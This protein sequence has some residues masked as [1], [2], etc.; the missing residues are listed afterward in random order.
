[1]NQ[2]ENPEIIKPDYIFVE[3]LL[4]SPGKFKVVTGEI[5]LKNKIYDKNLH[6]PQLA[7]AGFTE[8]FT[9][10]R[11]QIFGNTEMY[12]LNNMDRQKRLNA[13]ITMTKFPVPCIILTNGYSL[14][15]ELVE[16]AKREGI[17]I[18]ETIYE[19]TMLYS[20][21]SDF[22]SDQF[23]E[24]MSVHGSFV[25]VYGVGMLFVGKSGIGKSEIALDLIERGHR[26]VCDDI[27]V[28]TR[29]KENVIMG[30]G[31]ETVGHYMEIRGLGIVDIPKMFGLKAIRFQKRLEIIV[32]L[33]TWE[34]G[35]EYTRTGLDNE[36]LTVMGDNIYYVKLP[37]IPGKNITVIS[38]VIAVNY[39]LNT[40]GYNAALNFSENLMAKIKARKNDSDRF[41]DIRMVKYFLDEE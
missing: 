40:Y 21:M 31:T 10:K 29:R 26:L 30:T 41:E 4:K 9:F 7:L 39:L 15:E 23:S 35:K 25:D 19:T 27:V 38:E 11:V 22:L 36:N 12:Y 8:L 18:L 13:F 24:R 6:R 28:L 14:E 2:F 1:M 33:E 5:G 20:F 32:E 3:D 16:I 17:A 37:I 34:M